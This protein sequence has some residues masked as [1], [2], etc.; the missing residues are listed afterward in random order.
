MSFVPVY[1][2]CSINNSL[3]GGT[4]SRKELHNKLVQMIDSLEFI[5]IDAPEVPNEEASFYIGKAMEKV[6][7]AILN[8]STAIEKTQEE[9]KDEQA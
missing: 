8:L 1:C 2:V 5:I 3:N 7:S 6:S 9:G 4:M